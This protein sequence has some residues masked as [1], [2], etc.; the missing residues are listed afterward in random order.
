MKH[1]NHGESN[2]Q[3]NFSPSRNQM[4]KFC[5]KIF[6]IILI[7]AALDIFCFRWGGGGVL[8][9]LLIKAGQNRNLSQLVFVIS[10]LDTTCPPN[11]HG[12]QCSVS[13]RSS[14]VA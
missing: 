5:R 10:F 3:C 6:F 13:T 12:A 11:L 1:K 9:L 7:L 2:P 8:L 14:G 4:R